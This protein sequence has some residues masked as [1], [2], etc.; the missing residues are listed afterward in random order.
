MSNHIE[1]PPPRQERPRAAP[2]KQAVTSICVLVSICVAGLGLSAPARAAE[3]DCK[4]ILCLAGGFPGGCEDA[5]SYMIDRLRSVPPKPPHGNCETVNADGT[6][7]SYDGARSSMYTV[8]EPPICEKTRTYSGEDAG[9]KCVLWS[10][11]HRATIGISVDAGPDAPPFT[12]AY[13]WRSW[14]TFT[15]IDPAAGQGR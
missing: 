10:T 6:T 14:R 2:W 4:V 11:R 5:H 1:P 3:I 15:H 12:N 7:A 13:V 8:S 9:T